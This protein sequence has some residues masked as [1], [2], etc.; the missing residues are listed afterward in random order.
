MPHTSIAATAQRARERTLP[1]GRGRGRPT[2]LSSPCDGTLRCRL[3][4]CRLSKQRVD[5]AASRPRSA[6]ATR[7]LAKAVAVAMVM[8]A[9]EKV[10]EAALVLLTMTNTWAAVDGP[11]WRPPAPGGKQQSVVRSYLA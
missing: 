7:S 1:T 5:P 11:E 6:S 4:D 3:C 10:T 9:V 2:Y 8:K